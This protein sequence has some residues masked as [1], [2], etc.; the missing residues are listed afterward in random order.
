M[1]ATLLVITIVLCLALWFPLEGLA[2]TTSFLLLTVFILVN[3]ALIRIKLIQTEP[4]AGII[5]NP[6]WVPVMGLLTSFGL[7]MFQVL[8]WISSLPET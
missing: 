2:K 7:M 8:S 6:L 3:A 5:N 1:N 4:P